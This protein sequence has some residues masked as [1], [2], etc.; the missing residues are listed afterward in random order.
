MSSI[1]R[2]CFSSL[3]LIFLLSSC[4]TSDLLQSSTPTAPATFTPEA[5]TTEVI[6]P[7]ATPQPEVKSISIVG[8]VR[9]PAVENL[10]LVL[11]AFELQNPGIEV[12]YIGL[13]EFEAVIGNMVETDNAPDIALFPQPGAIM[14]LAN[15]GQLVPMWD[16]VRAISK[17]E[18]SPSWN[19]LTKVN[20][21]SYGLFSRVNLKGLVWYDKPAFE[22]AGF[23][24]PATWDEFESLI[25][26]MKLTGIAPFCEGIESGAATGW[27]GTDWIE[28]ILLLSQPVS[29]YD[30]WTTHEVPFNSAEV[31][32]AFSF[33]ERYWFDETIFRGGEETIG[34]TNFREPATWIFG[35]RKKCWLHMQ[36]TFAVNFFPEEIGADLDNN[37]GFFPLPKIN[38]SLPT[39]LEVGGDIWVVF[40][41]KDR[42]EVKALVEFLA[43]PQSANLWIAEG[44]A[45]FPHLNQD[46]NLYPSELDRGIAELI[47]NA[48]TVRFDASDN[49]NSD[50]NL[51]FWSELTAWV[52]NGQPIDETLENIDK[53]LPVNSE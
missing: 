25:E 29:V 9:G 23:D 42:E 2:I 24:V 20:D 22:A 3:L 50:V 47:L 19:D 32:D 1:H 6:E 30:Q 36:A 10:E 53:N 27:K 44:G 37:V 33:L 46:L 52:I 8:A 12:N 14:S 43:T 28:N 49:M 13:A 31:K 11:D 7:T 16:E 21:V 38:P 34:L 5:I 48:E 35:D 17:E 26:E 41:G 40:K 51:A 39:T 18:F 15:E 4:Q 45:I